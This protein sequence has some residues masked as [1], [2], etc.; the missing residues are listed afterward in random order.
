MSAMQ[1]LV[2]LTAMALAIMAVVTVGTVAAAGLLR[3]RARSTRDEEHPQDGDRRQAPQDVQ[4]ARSQRPDA[5]SAREQ[6]ASRALAPLGSSLAAGSR[7]SGPIAAETR[8]DENN[9]PFINNGEPAL[10]RR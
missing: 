1:Y 9:V 10:V 8:R 2:G 7:L 6:D 3:T 4:V 5:S